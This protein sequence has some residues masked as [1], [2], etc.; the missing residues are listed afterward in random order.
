MDLVTVTIPPGLPVSMTLGIIYAVEKMQKKNIFCTSQ[1][2]I[3]KGG[4]V[5]QVCFDKTGTLTENYM[6]F[7]GL[8]PHF[9][10]DFNNLI[11]N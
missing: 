4:R 1:N 8:I 2:N 11:K 7:Y 9:K 6:D 10:G 3:I 5:N